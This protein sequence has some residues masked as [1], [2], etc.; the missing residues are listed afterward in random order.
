MDR[1]KLFDGKC[2]GTCLFG[3]ESKPMNVYYGFICSKYHDE[4][5]EICLCKEYE[6]CSL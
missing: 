4:V 2:C 1:P 6:P 5:S 3:Y